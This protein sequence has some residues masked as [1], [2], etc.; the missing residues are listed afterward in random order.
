MI[1][2]T[3]GERGQLMLPATP[4][5]YL[6]HKEQILPHI[7][8]MAMWQCLQ[9]LRRL[10]DERYYATEDGEALLL[11][12]YYRYFAQEYLGTKGKRLV[13]DMA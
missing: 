5:Q 13:G 1:H 2:Q 3:Y 7:R 12:A 11:G 4:F 9:P 6:E 10:W 8:P